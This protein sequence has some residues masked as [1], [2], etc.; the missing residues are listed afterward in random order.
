MGTKTNGGKLVSVTE[1]GKR[2]PA[3]QGPSRLSV[4]KEMKRM[5]TEKDNLNA[6][7]E[8]DANPLYKNKKTKAR[9]GVDLNKINNLTQEELD[10]LIKALANT[11]ENPEL[12]LI[13]SLT[14]PK[15]EDEAMKNMLDK[16]ASTLAAPNFSSFR[17]PSAYQSPGFFRG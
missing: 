9:T 15:Q 13:K 16:F 5:E 6:L 2:L 7:E 1:Y 11:K 3:P 14:Q 8:V 4:E 17:A 12:D 10:E